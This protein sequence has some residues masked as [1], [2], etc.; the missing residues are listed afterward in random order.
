MLLFHPNCSRV[1]VAVGKSLD[2][3]IHMNNLLSIF[4]GIFLE[5]PGPLAVAMVLAAVVLA[6]SGVNR[7]H[8]GLLMASGV[9]VLATVALF[10]LS[11]TV[12]TQREEV[13]NAT[14]QL[15]RSTTDPMSIAGLKDKLS[16]QAR[17]IGPNG[18]VWIES[19]QL[20]S[21][22]EAL[23]KRWPIK[24]HSVRESFIRVTS[25]D[26]KDIAMA[27]M[28]ISTRSIHTDD[29]D[30][31]RATRWIFH[32]ERDVHGRWKVHDIQWTQWMG[33]PPSPG[34]WR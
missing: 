23:L 34:M 28:Q 31:G 17:L 29:L 5:S 4:Q 24:R 2:D 7:R 22:I 18:E 16:P 14:L 3:R 25:K 8:K 15:L 10:T 6:V 13:S 1:L 27:E 30:I 33:Q 26:G 11:V 19:D 21:E 12:V 20:I 9:L 32:W